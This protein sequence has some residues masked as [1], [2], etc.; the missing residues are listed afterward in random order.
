MT[1]SCGDD[2]MRTEYERRFLVSPYANWKA[3]IE[4]YSKA[5][6]DKY[7]SFTR[8]RLRRLTDSDTGRQLLKLNK[9]EESISPYFRTVSRI[10]LSPTEYVCLSALEGN[11]IRKT[12]HYHHHAGRVFSIDIFEGELEGLILC[13]TEAISL[14]ALM[15][16]ELPGYVRCEVTE[17][18]F[19]TGGNLCQVTRADLLRKLS[20]TIAP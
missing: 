3:K 19:F 17:D 6:E 2:S 15:D 7:L 9:K 18:I 14:D 5:F 16:A 8:L 13:E 12:R 11:E 20:E 1:T 4:P 10:L